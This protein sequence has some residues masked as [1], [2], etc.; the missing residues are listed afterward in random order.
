LNSGVISGEEKGVAKERVWS[1]RVWC[2]RPK[3]QEVIGETRTKV[4]H[5][6]WGARTGEEPVDA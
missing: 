6:S 4:T 3:Q 1:R 2:L 5:S